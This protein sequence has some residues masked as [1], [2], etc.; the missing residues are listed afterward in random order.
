MPKPRK[1]RLTNKVLDGLNAALSAI[2]AG[3]QLSPGGELEDDADAIA[4]ASAWVD[5]MIRYRKAR[6]QDR[7]APGA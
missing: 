4:S 1:P 5:A 3:D 2:E 7:G 6:D